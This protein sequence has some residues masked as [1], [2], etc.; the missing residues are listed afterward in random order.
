MVVI[1]EKL[2]LACS[3]RPSHMAIIVLI[4]ALTML[5]LNTQQT[6]AMIGTG[7]VG[8]SGTGA[9]STGATIGT[10]S[11]GQVLIVIYSAIQE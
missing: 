10:G 8:Q 2:Y 5:T 11:V 7:S 4:S 6:F 1:N 3:S 9:G